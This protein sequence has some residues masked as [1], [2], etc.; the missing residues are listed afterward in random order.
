MFEAGGK[1][2]ATRNAGQQVMN[3]FEKVVPEIFGGAADLTSSTKTIFKDSAQ[4]PRRPGGTQRVLRRARVRHVRHG[5]RHGGA[6]R[7]DSVWIDLLQLC[8][9]CEAG[10]THCGDHEVAFD[11]RVYARL[12]RAGRGW[13]D[14]PAD[15]AADDA[16]RG[17]EPD[18]PAAGG[19]ERDGGGVEGGAGDARRRRSWRCRGRT[20][21]CWMRRS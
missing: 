15:R 13:T 18:R 2:V 9:L 6:W 10:G 11:L 20:C 3:A 16:A 1:G 7:R 4:L 17:A 5:E 19:C 12:D 14:A 8:G 21:R